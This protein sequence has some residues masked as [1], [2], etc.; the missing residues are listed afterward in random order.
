MKA[1]VQDRYGPPDVVRLTDIDRPV[2]A[3]DRVLVRVRAASVNRADLDGLGPRPGFVRLFVGLRAPRNHG[4]GLDVAGVVESVGA[5][6]TRFR[7]GDEVF[8]DM[9]AFRQGA[10]AEYVCAREKAF[11]LMPTGMS[12]EDAA[13][14]PHSAVL[15]LQGLRLRNGRTP[16][17][18]DKVLIDGASGN[19]G[20]FAVQIAKSMGAEVTGVCSTDKVEFVRSLGADHVI[21]YKKVDYTSTGERYDWIVDTDSHHSIL[22]VRR[23]LRPKGVYVTLGGTSLPI[24]SALILGSLI[25]LASDRWTGLLIW[26]KP[27]HAPDVATLKELIAGG[28][29]KPVIDR[30]FRLDEVVDAL[31]YVDEGR[32]KGKVVI[33]M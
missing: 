13:T 22:R 9:F 26:W 27:F 29:V 32:P 11:E 25:S 12:F 21:D 31:R 3:D 19:V 6:V 4:V 33:T 7:P 2:P 28:K 16:R 15:A 5:G 17:A 18:G 20:P 24:L 8:G 30:R 10:F 23:A 1:A 14:F